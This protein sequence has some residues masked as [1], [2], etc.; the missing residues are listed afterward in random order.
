M[1]GRVKTFI[2]D[3]DIFP[4]DLNEIQDDYAAKILNAIPAGIILPTPMRTADPGFLLIA[5]GL[6]LNRADFPTLW[7][8]VAPEITAGNPWFGAGDG[9]TTFTVINASGRTLLAA[10]AGAD[11]DGAGP[12]T[13]PT[14][15]ALGAHGGEEA[16]LLTGPESGTNTNGQTDSL[17]GIGSSADTG[18]LL[19]EYAGSGSYILNEGD[20]ST[21][22]GLVDS[23][24]NPGH[25]SHVRLGVNHLPDTK[26]SLEARNADTPHNVMQP[27]IAINYQIRH[28]N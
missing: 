14:N 12:E 25:W 19:M 18:R 3:G 21:V 10:G 27:F 8:R 1:S 7:A 28:G 24:I 20:G 26:A 22:V 9:S 13:V 2:N 4:E 17:Q 5:G 23:S 6:L 11:L 15:R 16:H